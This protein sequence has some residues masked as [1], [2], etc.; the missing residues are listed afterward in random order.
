MLRRHRPPGGGDEGGEGGYVE[1]VSAVAPGAAGV[2]NPGDV[3]LHRPALFHQH[4]GTAG[5]LIGAA[6]LGGQGGEHGADVGIIQG[7]VGEFVH[8]GRGLAPGEIS[9][10]DHLGE[11]TR[12]V[13]GFALPV[14]KVGE[15]S[16]AVLGADG[17]GVEL[18]P[19]DG[20]FP[21]T[22]AHD[23]PVGGAG[24]DFQF[25]GHGGGVDGE[26][27][28]AG[29]SA[30]VGQVAQHAFAVHFDGFHFAVDDG[31]GLDDFAAEH[32]GEAL[33]AQADTEDGY[34]AGE[35]FDGGVGDA[36]VRGGSRSRGDDEALG[37]E[38][39]EFGNGDFPAAENPHFPAGIVFDDA[40]HHLVD[41]VGEGI[42]VVDQGDAVFRGG[43]AGHV[44]TTP[45]PRRPGPGL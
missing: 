20:Q 37:L 33:V 38:G 42:V 36:R 13:Q 5:H 23:F 2:Q 29:E 40:A 11:Q 18:H 12:T 26:G 16:R 25:I 39:L 32:F 35:G 7:T 27:V 45:P 4:R 24:G 14:E 21:V 30:G 1:G 3:Q 15:E 31:L 6:A 44:Q 28:V 41:V 34:S 10:G 22:Q 17:F 43:L 8:E 9:S 19:F